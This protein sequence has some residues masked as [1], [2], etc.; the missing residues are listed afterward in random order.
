M[1]PMI[2]LVPAMQLVQPSYQE[3]AVAMLVRIAH[4]Q[5]AAVAMHDTP[6]AMQCSCAS[7]HTSTHS[8]ASHTAPWTYNHHIC[9]GC[10]NALE[11]K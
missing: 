1:Q 7:N 8:S 10:L 6:S 11:L 4:H 9:R 5:E 3:A 2:L